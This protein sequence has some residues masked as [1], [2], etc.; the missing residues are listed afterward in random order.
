MIDKDLDQ[1]LECGMENLALALS[2][3]ENSRLALGRCRRLG[4][5]LADV[6]AD[7]LLTPEERRRCWRMFHAVAAGVREQYELDRADEVLSR[8]LNCRLTA[9]ARKRRKAPAN[10]ASQTDPLEA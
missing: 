8:E 7:G 3:Q 2:E 1:A 4:A 6:F 9:F 10:G 5:L